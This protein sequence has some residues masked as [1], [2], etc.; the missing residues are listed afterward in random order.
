MCCYNKSIKISWR[1]SKRK[2]LNENIEALKKGMKNLYKHID[3]LKNIF[4][5][6][7]IVAINKFNT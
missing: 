5:Q 2:I 3:N 1:S 7:V 4:G 6:N